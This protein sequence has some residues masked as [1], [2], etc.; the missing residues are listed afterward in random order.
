[1][2]L[3]IIVYQSNFKDKNAATPAI[4]HFVLDSTVGMSIIITKLVE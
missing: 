3:V 2:L 1:M 4:V